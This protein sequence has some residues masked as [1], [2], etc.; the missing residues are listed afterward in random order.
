MRDVPTASELGMDA[1]L[2]N[3]LAS[4]VARRCEA[5]GVRPLFSTRDRAACIAVMALDA[6]TDEWLGHR[7]ELVGL[8]LIR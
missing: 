3:A 7:G 4:R 1:V 5:Q 6:A 2:W 8:G